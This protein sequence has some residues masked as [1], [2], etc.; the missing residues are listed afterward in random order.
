[1]RTAFLQKIFRFQRKK[2]IGVYSC[3]AIRQ[4]EQH[5]RSYGTFKFVRLPMGLPCP[6]AIFTNSSRMVS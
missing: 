1:M 4:S 2:Q 6:P 5:A 3:P